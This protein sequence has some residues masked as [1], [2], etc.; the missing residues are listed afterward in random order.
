MSAGPI[1][2]RRAGGNLQIPIQECWRLSTSVVEAWLPQ[3][4]A[5]PTEAGRI[6]AA[7]S[8]CAECEQDVHAAVVEQTADGPELVRVR[9]IAASERIRCGHRIRR[10]V[11][12]PRRHVRRDAGFAAAPVLSWM[13]LMVLA[14]VTAAWAL[15]AMLLAFATA[16]ILRDARRARAHRAPVTPPP[17]PLLPSRHALTDDAELL[18]ELGRA[19]LER[20]ELPQMVRVQF[21]PAA[22]GTT[23]VAVWVCPRRHPAGLTGTQVRVHAAAG[24]LADEHVLTSASIQSADLKDLRARAEQHLAAHHTPVPAPRRPIA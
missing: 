16:W 18:A 15:M 21:V 9:P 13:A 7:I 20:D 6:L 10:S 3:S 19:V 1:V 4:P 14:A 24:R 2:V 11:P 22:A 17:P 12:V 23:P 5:R 8:V